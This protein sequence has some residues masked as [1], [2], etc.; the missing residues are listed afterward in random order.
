MKDKTPLERL[1]ELNSLLFKIDVGMTEAKAGTK[2]LTDLGF[3]FNLDY[4]VNEY[5]NI[6]KIRDELTT[7][8]QQ[9]EASFFAKNNQS[10]S[11]VEE[12]PVNGLIVEINKQK[13]T[14]EKQSLVIKN[15]QQ[16]LLNLEAK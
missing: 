1:E 13:D 15:L 6:K 14:I 16:R 12:T 11:I 10:N 7:S 9:S 2:T 3:E 8:I 4:I 5:N